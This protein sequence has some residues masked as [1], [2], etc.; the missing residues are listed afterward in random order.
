MGAMMTACS[1]NWDDSFEQ[2]NLQAEKTASLKVDVEQLVMNPEGSAATLAISTSG[3]W[4]VQC[5]ASW[6]TLDK[7]SGHGNNSINVEASLN[8]STTTA[9]SANI[10]VSNGVYSCSIKVEQGAQTEVLTVNT[11][12]LTFGWSAGQQAVAIS[13]NVNWTAKS[14]ASW[15]SATKTADGIQVNAAQNLSTTA[16]SATITITGVGLTHTITVSQAA[17]AAPEIT[18]VSV[19]GL[20]AHEAKAT[21]VAH[22]TDLEISQYGICYSTKEKT[23]ALGN[24]TVVSTTNQKLHSV[25]S[26]ADLVQLSSQSTYYLRAYIVTPLGT[27]YSDVVTFATKSAAPEEDDIVLPSYVK[28]Q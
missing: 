24:S 14:D 26:T 18:S 12:T 25:N 1:S 19:S 23:P 21:L 4:S 17:V 7:K 28:H 15:C 8:P 16:R 13:G 11:G 22:S 3:Y 6:L 5:D 9:R 20:T 27:L 2:Y 10:V